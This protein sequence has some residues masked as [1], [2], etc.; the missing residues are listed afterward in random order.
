MNRKTGGFSSPGSLGIVFCF[1]FDCMFVQSRIRCKTCLS[2]NLSD[3]YRFC[4]F[5]V[6][7]SLDALLSAFVEK[8]GPLTKAVMALVLLIRQSQLC[9]SIP[10]ECWFFAL[11]LLKY[12]V[13]TICSVP[14]DIISVQ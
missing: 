13:G 12:L 5:S 14:T 3:F 9:F 1:D 2:K 8:S 11:S 6:N 10:K 4:C 7:E